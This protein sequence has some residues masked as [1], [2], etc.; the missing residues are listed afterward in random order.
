MQNG[1]GFTR[2]TADGVVNEGHTILYGLH[3]EASIAGGDVSVY[4]GLDS[5]SGRLLG[6]FK[7]NANDHDILSFPHPVYL[8]RG[9]Y[10]DIGSNVTAVSLFWLPAKEP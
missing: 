5:E 9:L 4:E 1:V 7:E 2:L 3:I 6:T 8:D 10:V